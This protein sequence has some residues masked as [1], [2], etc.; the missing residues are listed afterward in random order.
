MN[1]LLAPDSFKG[2]MSALGVAHAMARGIRRADVNAKCTVLPMADGGEGTLDVLHAAR[3]GEWRT[4]DVI[5]AE[6]RIRS[7]SCLFLPKGVAVIEVA[8]V[9]GLP[10]VSDSLIDERSSEG[11][12]QLIRACLDAG[13]KRIVVA[14]GGSSTNDGG[15]GCLR[16]LGVRLLD[17]DE[18]ELSG[19]P[20]ELARLQRIDIDSLDSRLS[21]IRI[22]IWS[23]VDSPLLGVRGAS[24]L[25][26]R[27]KGASEQDVLT[28]EAA[29]LRFSLLADRAWRKK[30]S[31]RPGSGAA[32]GLGYALQLIGGRMKS[33]AAAVSRLC[34]LS[35]A[36][37]RA[38]WVVTGEGRSDDQTLGGKVPDEV[39]RLAREAGVPVT[40][41]CGALFPTPELLSAFDGC[42]SICPRPMTL[43]QSIEEAEA[44]IEGVCEQ[45]ARTILAASR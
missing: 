26:S 42:Y 8:R 31:M 5:D 28:L 9:I 24:R 2:C 15:A 4:F 3:E 21:S 19:C 16:A 10:D 11:V 35:K 32:G 25:F 27:Q 14:L 23:D 20:S 44:L 41:I 17:V 38:D 30:I 6:S 34:N 29:L 43:T 40:L 45:L 37:A 36:M 22:D 12:G 39:R 18:R 33:G 1:W 13:A 7:V